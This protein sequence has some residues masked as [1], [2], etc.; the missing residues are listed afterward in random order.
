M[1]RL[2]IVFADRLFIR[3]LAKILDKP[4]RTSAH[5]RQTR[6]PEKRKRFFFPLLILIYL[7][8]DRYKYSQRYDSNGDQ[9][10]QLFRLYSGHHH[11]AKTDK[12][13]QRRRRKVIDNNEKT[14][15]ARHD[16]TPFESPGGYISRLL[17]PEF[18]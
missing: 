14:E 18:R 12:A 1:L 16:K 7:D 13:Q 15:N 2:I 17:R 5:R 10:Q 11:H 9:R 4:H 8:R 6:G 3:R